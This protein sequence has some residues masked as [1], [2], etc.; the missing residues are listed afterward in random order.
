MI[1]MVT[2][3]NRR[4]FRAELEEMHQL[5]RVHFVEERGWSN[6]K[7][8]DGGEYDDY[9]DD[10]MIYFL[11][12]DE[13]GHVGVSMRARPTDDKCI[14]AD[15]FPQLIHPDSGP[16]KTA[17]TW[18]I[19]RIFATRKFRGRT[20][21]RRRDEVF[22]A[23]MEAAVTQGVTRL[24]GIID[25]YLLPQAMRFPWRLTPLGLP[26][27]Y[28]EGE[29]IGVQIPVSM[30][31]LNAAREA[32][33]QEGPIISPIPP[34]RSMLNALTPAQTR[35][36]IQAYPLPQERMIALQQLVG[37]VLVLQDNVE[38]REILAIVD[39]ALSELRAAHY[40]AH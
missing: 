1:Y 20:G 10:R 31:D 36:L 2:K 7:V 39:N 11:A 34:V 3:S 37:D 5:R 15:V 14:V 16:T 25:T 21:L 17:K 13:D 6:M 32:M 22:L 12:L 28:P 27:A 19:S 40:V 18:E 4:L 26:S 24:V 33:A 8:V 23:S 35:L 9:D 29:M 30:P 38:E